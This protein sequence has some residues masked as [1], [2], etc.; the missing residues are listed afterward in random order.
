M[1][2]QELEFLINQYKST[3]EISTILK[4]SQ[5]NVRYWLNKFELK[6]KSKNLETRPSENTRICPMCKIE[7]ELI[8]FYQKRKK[9]AILH[10]ANLA[11]LKK[12]L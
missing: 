12:P 5:T 9:L 8:F 3:R 6:T 1:Q 7:K 10:I 2:K 4:T 11:Q